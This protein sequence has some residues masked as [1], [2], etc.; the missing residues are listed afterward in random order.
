M[1]LGSNSPAARI[2]VEHEAVSVAL[3]DSVR[4]A[5]EHVAMK[6]RE[7]AAAMSDDIGNQK[8]RGRSLTPASQAKENESV[9][10]KLKGSNRCMV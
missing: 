9:R 5:F 8:E 1:S 7:Q 2:K 4:H 6:Y 10:P 3:K